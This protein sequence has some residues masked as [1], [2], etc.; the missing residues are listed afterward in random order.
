M[1]SPE[2]PR[3]LFVFL[4]ISVV[5]TAGVYFLKGLDPVPSFVLGWSL[6]LFNLWAW[7]FIWL[8][9]F[10]KKQ[11]ALA[12]AVIVFKYAILG[13]IVYLGA[14]QSWAQ[15]L[16]FVAG[17]GILIPSSLTKAIFVHFRKSNE[18]D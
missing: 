11:V 10:R 9:I 13:T 17:V 1:T 4:V 18:G 7:G 16:W 6:T 3:V 2:F 8:R 14:S 15:P 5:C 12:L